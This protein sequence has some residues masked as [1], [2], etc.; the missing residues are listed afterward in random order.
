VE[1]QRPGQDYRRAERWEHGPTPPVKKFTSRAAAVARLWA[2]VQRLS[3]DVAP[4][5]DRVSM[6][7]KKSCSFVIR[8]SFPKSQYSC[9]WNSLPHGSDPTPNNIIVSR[10]ATVPA[11]VGAAS[12]GTD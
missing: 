7:F 9:T 5:A 12:R 4:Q 10:A 11:F 3:P 1:E 8:E 6:C 2:A